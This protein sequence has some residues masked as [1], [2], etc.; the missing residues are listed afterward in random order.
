MI[1][2]GLSI[3]GGAAAEASSQGNRN[4]PPGTA[5]TNTTA[6]VN[7]SPAITLSGSTS[8]TVI[9]LFVD[10]SNDWS[11]SVSDYTLT[12]TTVNNTSDGVTAT[13]QTFSFSAD[14]GS[15]GSSPDTL[16]LMITDR[17]NFFSLVSAGRNDVLTVT[18]K[19]TRSGYVLQEVTASITY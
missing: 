15:F 3:V 10:E 12:D 13:N 8:Q 17:N 16:R 2:L 5:W 9:S 4:V 14:L 19:L 18:G 6:G 1:G 7:T 11:G